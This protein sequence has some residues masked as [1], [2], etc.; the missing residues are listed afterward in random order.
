MASLGRG[1]QEDFSKMA[2]HDIQK[3]ANV[4]N[5]WQLSPVEITANENGPDLRGD[6]KSGRWQSSVHS[7]VLATKHMWVCQGLSVP[8]IGREESYPGCQRKTHIQGSSLWN[9]GPQILAVIWASK[10][11]EKYAA[12]LLCCPFFMYAPVILAPPAI[13]HLG[14]PSQRALQYT[15]FEPMQ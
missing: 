13:C 15:P 4:Y 9:P 5:T 12:H 7:T 8:S 14:S 3:I 1:S 11:L 2:K 6:A 10:K